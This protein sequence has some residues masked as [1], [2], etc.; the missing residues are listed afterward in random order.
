M[1]RKSGK[2]TT[3]S[4]LRSPALLPLEYRCL[5]LLHRRIMSHFCLAFIPF[6]TLVIQYTLFCNWMVL[7]HGDGLGFSR[8]IFL[9]GGFSLVAFWAVVLQTCGTFYAQSL[10]NKRSWRV[11]VKDKYFRKWRKSVTPLYFGHPGYHVIKRLSILKFCKTIIRGTFRTMV[12][13]NNV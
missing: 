8:Y 12:T 1:N 5:E 13:L 10:R 7:A 11:V 4:S 3:Y 9:C 6:Q 2:Y